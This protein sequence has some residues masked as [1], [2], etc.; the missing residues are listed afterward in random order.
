MARTLLRS[1]DGHGASVS[2]SELLFDLI[3]VFAVTQ[4]S[5][6]LLHHLTLT[7]ALQ[8]LV[9]WFAVW[10]AWQYTAWVTNWFDPDTRQIRLLLFAIMLLGLFAAA[11]LPEA[12]GE[13]G[14]V[15]ALSFAAIQV[16][17]SLVILRLL[18]RDNPLRKNF[19]RIL[20]W[21]CISALFWIIGGFTEGHARLALWAVAVLC[22]YLSP[23][24]GFRLPGLGRSDSNQEWTIEG[25]HLAERCQLF[26]IVALG[27]TILITGATLSELE[28]WS[29]PIVIAALVAF[30][31]SLAMWWVYFDTSSK[32]GS[33]AITHSKNPGQ[34]GAWFHYIHVVLVGA[35]I[36]CAVA[37]EQV[38]AHPDER[39]QSVT[40]V[41]L[42]LGPAIYILANVVYKRIIH[43]R[44]PL[45]HLI[46]LIAF[47]VLF[48]LAFHTDL[49]M[50]SGLTTVILVV[51]GIWESLSRDKITTGS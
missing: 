43:G 2:F 31:G 42:I 9:L 35:I 29:L 40:A 26:V 13:R 37:N 14:M 5:H 7:G 34:M 19:Q 17:R 4:L 47:I 44:F 45:S 27:E 20:G 22:E 18:G 3:Y 10:L 21:L 36:V 32:T 51:I 39:I 25:H 41:V 23:M 38:I 49:L 15:F 28:F 12:F 46:G 24:F 11:A 1:R 50:V 16:G 30:V 33:H 48:P 6:Y 8:T